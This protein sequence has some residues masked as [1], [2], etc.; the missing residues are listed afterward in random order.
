MADFPHELGVDVV[1]RGLD[2]SSLLR[3]DG[4]EAAGLAEQQSWNTT[5]CL[6]Q[7]PRVETAFVKVP[8]QDERVVGMAAYFAYS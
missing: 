2:F 1:V 5:G 8:Y 7:S 4:E 6:S 3:N